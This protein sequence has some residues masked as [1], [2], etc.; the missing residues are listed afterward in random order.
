[1][2]QRPNDQERKGFGRGKQGKGKVGI[3]CGYPPA[4]VHTVSRSQ[5][6]NHTSNHHVHINLLTKG[7]PLLDRLSVEPRLTFQRNLRSSHSVRPPSPLQHSFF[8]V[9][10]SP[11][12]DLPVSLRRKRETAL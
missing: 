3:K 8:D 1:M 7:A 5:H 10:C 12:S 4:M 2:G 9:F 6:T 11:T